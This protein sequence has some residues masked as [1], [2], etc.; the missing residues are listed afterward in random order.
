MATEPTSRP[1]NPAATPLTSK[2]NALWGRPLA[3]SS[4]V[5]FCISS[6]FPV[7]VGL[8]KD[9]ASFP[10]GWGTLDVGIA[11]VLAALAFAV[12]GLAKGRVNQ[13]VEG[14]SYRAYRVLIHGIFALLLVFALLG[15]RIVWSNC[16]TG[17]AWRFWLLLYVLPAWV[18]VFGTTVGF[19]GPPCEARRIMIETRRSGVLRLLR[20]IFSL[21]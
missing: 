17:L 13:Q 3:I 18:A 20:G 10:P 9:T 12:F 2:P 5:V 19:N 11:F 7:A 1:A 6:V 15:D 21:Q 4:A 14:L 8:A 16:L